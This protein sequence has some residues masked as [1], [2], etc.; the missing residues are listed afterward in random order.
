MT[1]LSVTAPQ[2]LEPVATGDS[3]CGATPVRRWHYSPARS[4]C[5]VFAYEGCGGTRNNFRSYD[6]CAAL[7][8]LEHEGWLAV[9][10]LPVAVSSSTLLRRCIVLR[11]AG[12]SCAIGF[13]VRLYLP[14][15]LRFGE[16]I[17]TSILRTHR[18]RASIISLVCLTEL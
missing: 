10:A 16:S 17:S 9:I 3:W 13:Q 2:C 11:S 1:G 6:E 12:L 8:R 7:C 15:L 18:D 14:H 5:L 4:D